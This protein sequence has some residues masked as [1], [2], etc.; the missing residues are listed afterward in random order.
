MEAHFFFF[1][2]LVLSCRHWGE[3][4]RVSTLFLKIPISCFPF[5]P[6]WVAASPSNLFLFI[7]VIVDLML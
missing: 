1:E 4:C 3:L 6:F 5:Y 2:I 7:I